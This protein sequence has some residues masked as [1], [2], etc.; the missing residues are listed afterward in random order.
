MK[1]ETRQTLNDLLL[2][3]TVVSGVCWSV[4]LLLFPIVVLFGGV[5]ALVRWLW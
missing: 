4:I 5:Y 2:I 3:G 1:W